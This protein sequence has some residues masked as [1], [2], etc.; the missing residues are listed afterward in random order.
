MPA[1]IARRARAACDELGASAVRAAPAPPP[2]PP[3]L[4]RWDLD[5]TYLR[6][7]FDTLRQL[8][9]R[10]FETRRGQGRG[11][12]RRRAHQGAARRA[13]SGAGGTSLVYFV[14]ASPPQIGKA[15]RD[16]LALDGVPYDGI[17]FKNQ[18]EHLRRGQAPATCA[19]TSA[20]SSSSSCAAGSAAPAERARAA[21]RRRLGVGSAHLLALRRHPRRARSAPSGSR[22]SSPASR[23]DP[24]LRPRDRARSRARRRRRRRRRAHLHQPRAADA[25][26]ASSGSF[27]AARRADLQLLPDRAACSPPTAYLDADD[28]GARRRASLLERSGYTPRRLENSLADLVRRGHLD[29]RRG[30]RCSPQPL[31]AARRAAAGGSRVAALARAHARRRVRRPPRL[32]VVRFRASP[33]A[34]PLDYDAIL[35][36]LQP[37]AT[38]TAREGV[39]TPDEFVVVLVTAGSADEARAHRPHARRGAARRVRQRR[40]ADPLD[41][42]LAGRGRGRRANGSSSLK[43][44]AAD[45]PALEARVRALHSLRRSRGAR[46]SR[47]RRARRRISHGST[48]QPSATAEI[49][50]GTAAGDA[51]VL[52]RR[53]RLPARARRVDRVPGGPAHPSRQRPRLDPPEGPRRGRRAHGGDGAPRGARG[54]GPRG[55]HHRAASATSPTGTRGARSRGS[56]RASSSASASS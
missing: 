51:R 34:T 24:E 37:P 52:R 50:G 55:R 22:R 23:V 31:R 33:R 17:V 54:D 36:R 41:L 15:I 13:P 8:C 47:I 3:L 18:L 11:A 56:R 48:R 4:C 40:R 46:A 6:S 26:G 49:A 7:E 16:K 20:S 28:V 10:R 53:A 12:G 5:K 14:S 27:G 30:R 38:P 43:A 42:P 45:V 39:M 9:G 2:P 44:R 21:L 29:R 1:E 32:V 35:D 19:S 25:A